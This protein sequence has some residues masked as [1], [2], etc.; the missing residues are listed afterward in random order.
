MPVL[1]RTRVN[2]I[3]RRILSEVDRPAWKLV[4]SLSSQSFGKGARDPG[5]S[6]YTL[7]H[8]FITQTNLGKVNVKQY[9]RFNCLG[10]LI[11]WMPKTIT[12]RQRNLIQNPINRVTHVPSM[13]IRFCYTF[14]IY[15]PIKTSRTEEID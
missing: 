15:K 14:C 12:T 3:E 11:S 13:K 4:N 10:Y 5:T 7:T 1:Y 9:K 6:F 2:S 8:K